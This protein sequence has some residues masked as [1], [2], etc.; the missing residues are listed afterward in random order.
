MYGLKNANNI[1]AM[2]AGIDDFDD[3][4]SGYEIS[5][6]DDLDR[7]LGAALRSKSGKSAL[8]TLASARLTPKGNSALGKTGRTI[9]RLRD[10]SKQVLTQTG[11]I[12][13]EYLRRPNTLVAVYGPNLASGATDDFTITPGSGNSY[14]RILGLVS[15]DDQA[16]VF[17][18][19][20][21]TVGGEDH[22]KQRQTDPTPPVANAVP[23][24]IFAL[25]ESRMIANLAPWTGQVFDNSTPITGTIVNM[26]TAGGADTVTLAPRIVFLSQTDPCGFRYAQLNEAAKGNWK[27]MRRNIGSYAPMLA[28][29]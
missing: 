26:T 21:L 22:V 23:W 8:S 3:D 15:A 5:G 27:S 9:E 20:N 17:G 4:V 28:F 25:K 16:N 18:F 12:E 1:G 2:I 24:S 7:M 13:A 10:I 6:E 19:S 29:N 14:Y 11:R